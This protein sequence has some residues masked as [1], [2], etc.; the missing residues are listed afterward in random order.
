MD[1]ELQVK[2]VY[3]KGTVF[4]FTLEV[5][6]KNSEMPPFLDIMNGEEEEVSPEC[7][8]SSFVDDLCGRDFIRELPNFRNP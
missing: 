6:F 7:N 3:G 1:S 4:S 5:N 8:L 2:S